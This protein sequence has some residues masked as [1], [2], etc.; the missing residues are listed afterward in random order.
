MQLEL[1][2]TT[3]GRMDTQI[4]RLKENIEKQNKEND[5]IRA[6]ELASQESQKKLGRQLRDLREDFTTVQGKE[7]DLVQRKA[8][9]EKQLEVSEVEVMTVKADLKLAMK[10]IED[11]QVAIS[12]DIDSETYSD[13]GEESSEDESERTVNIT[14]DQSENESHA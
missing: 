8:D 1:E 5:D 14:E 7:T 6:R 13:P 11:L 2:L 10:R 4:T 9:L 3:R 12:G